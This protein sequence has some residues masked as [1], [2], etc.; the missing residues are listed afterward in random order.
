MAHVLARALH[1]VYNAYYWLTRPLTL[2]VRGLIVDDGRV[3]LVRHTYMNGWYLPGGGI[4]KGE[5][6]EDA[7]RR[8]LSEEVGVTFEGP[9]RLLGVYS[10]FNQFKSDHIVLFQVD[11]YAMVPRRNAEIAEHAFFPLTAVPA[12]TSPGTRRRLDELLTGAPASFRW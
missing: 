4:D 8:E 12:D 1:Q 9:P 11:R 6:V 5:A 3:L 2:G 7:L 10:N